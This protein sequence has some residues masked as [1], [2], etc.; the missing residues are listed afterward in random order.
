MGFVDILVPGLWLGTV[1]GWQATSCFCNVRSR[2]WIIIQLLFKTLAVQD[3]CRVDPR[4]PSFWWYPVF[5]HHHK[6][7]QIPRV[8][9]RF[10]TLSTC[11]FWAPLVLEMCSVSGKKT[12]A[13]FKQKTKIL[14][15]IF[16]VINSHKKVLFTYSHAHEVGSLSK[17]RIDNFLKGR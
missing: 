12:K 14:Q 17:N 4:F 1:S 11:P 6:M 2:Q 10:S 8:D 15:F 13:E 16:F 9:G 3:T 7:E 5:F